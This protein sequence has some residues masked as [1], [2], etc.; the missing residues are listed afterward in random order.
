M[1]SFKEKFTRGFT[2]IN[3]KT[4]NLVEESKLRTYIS[5]LENDIVKSKQSIGDYV[6]N[7]WKENEAIEQ[8]NLSSI[9]PL[10][11]AIDEKNKE[12]EIQLNQI[13]LLKEE[14][15]KI[16]GEKYTAT[17]SVCAKCGAVNAAGNIFCTKCG[18]KLNRI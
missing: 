16:L 9:V 4:S 8:M 13:T 11:L 10:L 6:F 12:I 15:K 17:D 1:S 2:S 18:H 3:V 7:R 5:T 14:T